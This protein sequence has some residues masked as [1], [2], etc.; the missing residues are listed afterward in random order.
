VATR[1]VPA[2][3]WIVKYE[4]RKQLARDLLAGIAVSFLIVPQGL[5]YAGVAGLPAIHG[6]CACAARALAPPCALDSA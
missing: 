5:S 1:L 3:T 6:L 2:L 4:P